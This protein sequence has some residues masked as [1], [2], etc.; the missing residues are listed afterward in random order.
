MRPTIHARAFILSAVFAL[1]TLAGCATTGSFS[2]GDRDRS[3]GSGHIVRGEHDAPFREETSS[4]AERSMEV[5]E[6]TRYREP[7][8]EMQCWRCR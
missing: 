7:M 3:H 8:R 6:P 2:G 4:R 5:R 1:S